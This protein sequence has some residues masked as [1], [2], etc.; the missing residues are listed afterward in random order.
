MRLENMLH[1]AA[2]KLDSKIQRY[3]AA[4]DS[5]VIDSRIQ[6]LFSENYEDMYE[7]FL[8]VDS[9]FNPAVQN[10]IYHHPEIESITF[11]NQNN[12]PSYGSLIKPIERISKIRWAVN[13]D[14]STSWYRE[15]QSFFGVRKL[16]NLYATKD[17]GI[18]KIEFDYNA[19]FSR[20]IEPETGKYL[21]LIS[22]D[23][24]VLYRENQLGTD[25]YGFD[26]LQ[27]KENIITHL[28]GVKFLVIN[29]HLPVTGWEISYF[30]PYKTVAAGAESILTVTTLIIT[31]C[32]I[33]LA[34]L[35]WIFTRIFVEPILNLNSQMKAVEYGDFSVS[36][37]SSSSDEI[38]QLINRF[39]SMVT[40]IN[41]L[42]NEV[43]R[44]KIFR[45]E[46]EIKALQ[47]QI[48]PHFLYNTLSMINWRAKMKR[49]DEI[50]EIVNAVTRYY[51]TSLSKG[52]DIIPIRDEI[53]NIKSYLQIQKIMHDDELIIRYNIQEEIYHFFTPKLLLQPLVE[54]AVIHG[55]D[56][57]K[58]LPKIIEIEGHRIDNFI[59]FRITDNGP[60]IHP[61]K[62]DLGNTEMSEC[63]GLHNVHERIVHYFGEEYGLSF[64][65]ERTIGTSVIVYIP[66]H[67]ISE[68]QK[69]E[70]ITRK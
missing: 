32:L 28:S 3:D 2:L 55:V 12:V 35:I 52:K 15:N 50:S 58:S 18:L 43:Y 5:L 4:F 53:E 67:K 57:R 23:N 39:G 6:Q 62:T 65:R 22:M 25:V 70:P 69:P 66:V 64:D 61:E 29:D 13:A 33:L 11:F 54:N 14:S 48:N 38:G 44:N 9:G 10:I 1:Q 46:A 19:T 49:S 30:T 40:R 26:E 31:A 27:N 17:L 63:Y 34:V 47:A 41:N 24:A 59:L 20:V 8:Q 45:R 42:I 37:T 51:R 68:E 7:I 60:G 16:N 36:I 56:K 21:V